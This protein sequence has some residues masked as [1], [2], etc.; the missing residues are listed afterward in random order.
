MKVYLRQASDG[1]YYAGGDRW[2]H[3][4]EHAL[5][6]QTIKRATQVGNDLNLE[7]L[8]VVISIGRPSGDWFLPLRRRQAA[9]VKAE[10]AA[11]ETPFPKA[12]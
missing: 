7:S 5:E 1:L 6:L 2:V 8:E 11:G 9:G 4:P 12:A 10:P 3:D